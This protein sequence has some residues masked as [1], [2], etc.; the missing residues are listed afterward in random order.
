MKEPAKPLQPLVQP[1]VIAGTEKRGYF[2]SRRERG[3]GNCE[4]EMPTR[5]LRRPGFYTDMPLGWGTSLS[6][7][8]PVSSSV[9][10]KGWKRMI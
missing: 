2:I 5:L 7:S 1:L 4:V 8:Q 10:W 9:Q 3:G 6:L